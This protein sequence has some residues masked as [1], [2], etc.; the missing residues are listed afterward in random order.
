MFFLVFMSR[1]FELGRKLRCDIAVWLTGGVD[2]QSRGDNFYRLG[3]IVSANQH[4][5]SE[6]KTVMLN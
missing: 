6:R 4:R 5:T 3:V 1:D 2:R